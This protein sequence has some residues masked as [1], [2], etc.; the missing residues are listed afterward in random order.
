[1]PWLKAR[2]RAESR[3]DAA[4]GIR[5]QAVLTV[6]CAEIRGDAMLACPLWSEVPLTPEYE[7][8]RRAWHRE[9]ER[10]R[11]EKEPPVSVSGCPEE[12]GQPYRRGCG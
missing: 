12:P 1:M 7:R 10:R 3:R 6:E 4:T 5:D 8:W 11:R 9:R 2:A